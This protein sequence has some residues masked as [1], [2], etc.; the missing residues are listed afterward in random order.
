[1]PKEIK[2][3][4][5]WFLYFIVILFMAFLIHLIFVFP[6]SILLILLNVPENALP[7]ITRIGGLLA[8]ALTSYVFYKWSVQTFIIPQIEQRTKLQE[9]SKERA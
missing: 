1:M 5:G 3:L 2:F 6:I 4:Q 7:I 8:F 9:N